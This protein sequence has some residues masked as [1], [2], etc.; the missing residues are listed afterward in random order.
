M[1]T[2]SEIVIR[3]L[4]EEIQRLTWKVEYEQGRADRAEKELNA[5]MERLADKEDF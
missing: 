1:N 4:C 5:A 3:V 2:N